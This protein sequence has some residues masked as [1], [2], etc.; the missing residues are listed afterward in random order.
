M[1]LENKDKKTFCYGNAL[2]D[3]CPVPFYGKYDDYGG[4][5]DCHGFGLNIVV[6]AIRSQLYEFG[7]GPNEYHDCAVNKGNFDIAKLFEA[8]HEDHLGVQKRYEH[9]S[10]DYDHRALE[11][12]QTEGTLTASQQFELDRLAFKIKRVDAFR[13]VTHVTIHGD[14]F[15]DIMQN[16]Y[17]QQYVGGGKGNTGYENNYVDIYFKDIEASIPEYIRRMKDHVDS[18][19]IKIAEIAKNDPSFSIS[20]SMM[21]RVSNIGL[22]DWKDP[23]LAGRWLNTFNHGSSCVFG[24]IDVSDYIYQY[25]ESEDW[26]GLASFIKEVLTVVWIDA[27]M[28]ETR[29]IW[30]KQS[31]AGGQNNEHR[32]YKVLSNSILDILKKEQAEYDYENGEDEDETDDEDS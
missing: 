29:K 6:D 16:W 19:K 30:T 20:V 4:V 8:D 15:R 26:E 3:V 2:Y 11:E 9:D 10:D 24:L 17:I 31:G 21:S 22:F 27:F 28:S 23:C 5:D 18:I 32:G 12:K 14:I 1:L 7:Q 13:A 25:M